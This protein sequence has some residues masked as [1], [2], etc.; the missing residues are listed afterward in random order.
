[1]R[2]KLDYK[3]IAHLKKAMEEEEKSAATINKYCQDVKAFIRYTGEGIRVT[4]EHVIAYKKYL[5]E[6]YEVSSANSMLAAVNYF[7]RF[8]GCGEYAV[9]T[10]KVQREPFRNKE[11]ELTVEE[12]QRLL[13]AARKS[14]NERLCLIMQTICATGIRISE[15]SFITVS[16]LCSRRAQVSLK[17]KTRTVILPLELCNKLKLY[18]RKRGISSGS[19]FVTRSGKPVDRSNILH[20]MKKLCKKAQVAESKVFPHNLRHLFAVTF[21]KLE[22][23]ICHLADLLGHS[24]INT[25]RIYTLISCEEQ[26]R[27]LDRLCLCQ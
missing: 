3:I 25:T 27:Q 4:K 23:D 10:F 18:I 16:A 22:K 6:N 11:R 20:S 26:E 24:N 17:G 5:E 21:Y 2:K 13:E 8:L 14:G 9:K 12:Y 1:M 19:V 7:L 15:L